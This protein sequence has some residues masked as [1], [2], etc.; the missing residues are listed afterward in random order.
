MIEVHYVISDWDG[1]FKMPP[2][3]IGAMLADLLKSVKYIY[4]FEAEAGK[5]LFIVRRSIGDNDQEDPVLRILGNYGIEQKPF[6]TQLV[7]RHLCHPPAPDPE[8]IE[9]TSWQPDINI[10]SSVSSCEQ[11]SEIDRDKESHRNNAGS[12]ANSGGR[13]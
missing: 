5:P 2:E 4:R 12:M 9:H 6:H 13:N 3:K 10:S 11:S 8:S 1:G 7:H